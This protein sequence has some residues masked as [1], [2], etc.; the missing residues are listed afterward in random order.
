MN[1]GINTK[2]ADS[3]KLLLT[4]V[5]FTLCFSIAL[6]GYTISI[7]TI[8]YVGDIV[9][10]TGESD[11]M[12][13]DDF[14]GNFELKNPRFHMP[15][16]T[17]SKGIPSSVCEKENKELPIVVDLKILSLNV[18]KECQFFVNGPYVNTIHIKDLSSD[19]D[20]LKETIYTTSLKKHDIYSTHEIR[21]C[22]HSE[23]YKKK[24]EKL[25]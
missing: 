12:K 25:C 13:R 23:C 19:K 21:V 24:L 10:V 7:G 3:K 8:S 1:K 17:I 5:I 15:N 2:K 11:L 20:K 22:C 14:K 16:S 18:G 9:Q 4:L 6:V